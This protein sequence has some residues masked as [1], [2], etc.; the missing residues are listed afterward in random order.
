M[1]FHN[2]E[3]SFVNDGPLSYV[4]SSSQ[5]HGEDEDEDED[6]E[7]TPTGPQ[8]TSRGGG[9]GEKHGGKKKRR[10]GPK[11]ENDEDEKVK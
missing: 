7:G 2:S 8:K 6:T 9:G 3:D 5:E 10:K 11:F 1:H 4:T